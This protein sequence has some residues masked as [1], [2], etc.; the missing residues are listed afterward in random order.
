MFVKTLNGQEYFDESQ[1]EAMN[2]GINDSI[3]NAIKRNPEFTGVNK[4][5]VIFTNCMT[6][7]GLEVNTMI[8]FEYSY[9]NG[10]TNYFRLIE[11][12]IF[13]NDDDAGVNY[14]LE[15][16]AAKDTLEAPEDPIDA[17][18]DAMRNPATTFKVE[19]E[20]LVSKDPYVLSARFRE[21]FNHIGRDY[22]TGFDALKI[23]LKI[24]KEK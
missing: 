21:E 3:N 9:E 1:Q 15:H 4:G 20:K 8:S 6:K 22:I 7:Q 5:Q 13:D 14:M 17:F 10:K 19:P 18:V 24:L 12:A 16:R 11:I 2:W 23:V